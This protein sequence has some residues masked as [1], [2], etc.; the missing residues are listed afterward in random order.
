[1]Q[2]LHAV[3]AWYVNIAEHGP[4]ATLAQHPQRVPGIDA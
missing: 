1:M 2:E 4:M 3:H